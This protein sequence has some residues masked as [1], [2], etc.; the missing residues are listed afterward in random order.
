MNSM[1]Q[2]ISQTG[3]INK[4][5]QSNQKWIQSNVNQKQKEICSIKNEAER[6][7]SIE[8]KMT[9]LASISNS[10]SDQQRKDL[11]SFNSRSSLKTTEEYQSKQSQVN[12]AEDHIQDQEETKGTLPHYL[13]TKRNSLILEKEN[14]TS[15]KCFQEE[16][17]SWKEKCLELQKINQ[18]NNRQQFIQERK[19]QDLQ[20]QLQNERNKTKFLEKNQ[21]IVLNLKKE[22][23]E[24]K[25]KCK[26]FEDKLVQAQQQ[27]QSYKAHDQ[28]HQLGDSSLINN[29]Q[30]Q[31]NYV[32]FRKKSLEGTCKIN[33]ESRNRQSLSKLEKNKDDDQNKA[34]V[35]QMNQL[36]NMTQ[37]NK[38]L[39][40]KV[41][42]QQKQIEYLLDQQLYKEQNLEILSQ[43]N[44]ILGNQLREYTQ[45][46]GN[47]GY[48]QSQ[49]QIPNLISMN[50]NNLDQNQNKFI[51]IR[52]F[53]GIPTQKNENFESISD[54]SFTNKASSQIYFK[55][56]NNKPTCNN[57]NDFLQMQQLKESHK[58]KQQQCNQEN[59]NLEQI[60]FQELK[61]QIDYP[62]QN[63]I[64]FIQDNG[65]NTYRLSKLC[66]C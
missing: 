53:S 29:L 1:K 66:S 38:S 28:I 20:I 40:L 46:L 59:K 61:K 3:Q 7:I 22:L 63:E 43:E 14:L 30:T 8:P 11:L 33:I 35:L 10:Q 58:Q 26:Q 5:N 23:D 44:A 34:R 15:Q 4:I 45:I 65:E 57:K 42:E 64:Q 60:H 62:Y 16:E 52:K 25:I 27:M 54:Q 41:S 56:D 37:Q 36:Y 47:L 31:H 39:I 9:K 12:S 18:E 6:R 50:Q 13:H 24:E 21:E 2:N 32:S 55:E 19:I 51:Q 48:F 49:K 17:G